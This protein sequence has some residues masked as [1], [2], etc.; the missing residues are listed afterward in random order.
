MRIRRVDLYLIGY[1]SE[2]STQWY[3]FEIPP[4]PNDPKKKCK[5]RKPF[6]PGSVELPFAEGYGAMEGA[7]GL[8]EGMRGSIRL[9]RA[10]LGRAVKRLATGAP[11]GIECAE[12]C[13]RV[14]EMVP[15]AI[16]FNL[17]RRETIRSWNRPE[18]D[19]PDSMAVGLTNYWDDA[20]YI[21]LLHESNP[22][23]PQK[24]FDRA[25]KK[26]NLKLD[27]LLSYLG[28]AK[29]QKEDKGPGPSSGKIRRV[30]SSGGGK[31]A[32]LCKMPE[33]GW[34]TPGRPMVDL[35]SIKVYYTSPLPPIRDSGD[36]CSLL[37]NP[38]KP[39]K[40]TELQ[41]RQKKF[42]KPNKKFIYFSSITVS[43]V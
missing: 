7:A 32:N 35:R 14:V 38:T 27:D 37:P 9:G 17:M 31:E 16:R 24:E 23:L 39:G 8:K 22:E 2:N 13:I 20:S 41:K 28:I 33:E 11:T 18:G 25:F 5:A 15:E 26:Y 12:A 42:T 6:I 40:L 19:R 10:D 36:F 3:E 34:V 21:A 4:D 1:R 30:E 29:H 43:D